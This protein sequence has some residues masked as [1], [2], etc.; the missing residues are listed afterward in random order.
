MATGPGD[1]DSD[2]DEDYSDM[3]PLVSA[4]GIPVDTPS[5]DEAPEAPAPVAGGGGATGATPPALCGWTAWLV[6]AATAIACGIMVAIG[7]TRAARWLGL[8]SRLSAAATAGA[9]GWALRGRWARAAPVSPSPSGPG[10][11][12]PAPSPPPSPGPSRPPEEDLEERRRQAWS[13]FSF[14]IVDVGELRRLMAL[15]YGAPTGCTVCEYSATIREEQR[16]RGRIFISID[17]RDSLLPGLHF[18]GDFR[19]VL[20]LFHWPDGVFCFTPCTH[21][22]R[23]DDYLPLKMQDGRA[24]HCLLLFVYAFCADGGCIFL[25]QP[26]TIVSDYLVP[27]SADFR[28]CDAG[29]PW[30]KRFQV[31]LRGTSRT[32]LEID[33]GWSV[34]GRRRGGSDFR[35]QFKDADA[36]DRFR[37]SWEDFPHTANLIV[38]QVRPGESTP[39]P[40]DYQWVVETVAVRWHAA[41]LPLFDR[42][43]ERSGIFAPEIEAYPIERG[44]GDGRRLE[45]V[46]P[47]SMRVDWPIDGPCVEAHK[48]DATVLP[49]HLLTLLDTGAE[50]DGGGMV[51]RWATLLLHARRVAPSHES[52][53]E[54]ALLRCAEVTTGPEGRPA[55]GDSEAATSPPAACSALAQVDLPQAAGELPLWCVQAAMSTTGVV[56]AVVA[57]AAQPLLLAHA[58][59]MQIFGAEL[60][61]DLPCAPTVRRWVSTLGC[62]GLATLPLGRYQGAATLIALPV[63]GRPKEEAV[64][65]S[66]AVRL[67]RVASGAAF[68]W[69]T[70]AALAGTPV[71]DVAAR[72]FAGIGGHA[73]GVEM[74]S[75]EVRTPGVS[76]SLG[77][78][79]LEDIAKTHRIDQGPAPLGYDALRENLLANQRLRDELLDDGSADAARW[80][81]RVIDIN[82]GDIPPDLLADL[83]NFDASGL[84]D[85]TFSEPYE[86]I[87]Q[88]WLPRRPQQDMSPT[89][90]CVRRVT[91]FICD[92][93]ARQQVERFFA[94]S[95]DDL[96][97]IHQHGANAERRRPSTVVVTQEQHCPWARGRYFDCTFSAS[98]CCVPLDFHAPFKS[99]LN[100]EMLRRELADY[101]DQR[102]LSNLV[103]GVR[104][105][106]DVELNAVLMPHLESLP[107]GFASVAKELGRM[108]A[109]PLQWYWLNATPPYWP[110][111]CNGKGAVSRKLE[112]DRYRPTTEAGAPRKEIYGTGGR[113]VLSLNQASRL[114]HLPLHYAADGRPEMR[115]WLAIKELPAPQE[116]ADLSLEEQLRSSK[117][118]KE[119]KPTIAHL[120]RD[121][122]RLRR[123]AHL[124]GEPIYLLTDDAKDYFP[125]FG[126]APEEYPKFTG[127]F[128]RSAVEKLSFVESSGNGELCFVSERVLGFGCHAASNIAQRASEA[129]LHIFRRRMDRLEAA[130]LCA[131]CDPRPVFQQWREGRLRLQRRRGV[132]GN[133]MR[134]YTSLMYT[135]DVV[136]VVV[137]VPRALRLIREWR[138]FLEE[139]GLMMA[140]PEKR[141]LGVWAP[142]LGINFYPML[143]LATVPTAKLL[144]AVDAVQDTLEGSITFDK[145]RSL[146]GLLEHI[147]SLFGYKKNIMF[148]LYE[149]HNLETGV[150]A[151]GPSAVV[152]PSDL[153]WKQLLAWASR[154]ATCGGISFLNVMDGAA[155]RARGLTG[156]VTSDAANDAAAAGLGGFCHGFYWRLSL[157]AS[158]AS[159]MHITL[160]EFL[161]C[162]FGF[163][164]F[165]RLLQRFPRVV[166]L[167]DAISTPYALSRESERSPLLR[168]AHRLL[169]Q[170]E[171]F[172]DLAPRASV[173]HLSG[174]AN[175]FSDAVSRALWPRLDALARQLGLRLTPMDL[176]DEASRIFD[177]CL[178][179]C[180]RLAQPEPLTLVAG[181]CVTVAQ[182]DGPE[183]GGGPREL[184]PESG[185]ATD[186]SLRL[187]CTGV[188]ANMMVHSDPALR[189][190][191]YARL[192][193]GDEMGVARGACAVRDALAGLTTGYVKAA[194]RALACYV[195]A[196]GS[197]ELVAEA[198]DAR[199]AMLLASAVRA[200]A[201][202]RDLPALSLEEAADA[203]RRARIR[204]SASTREL[205]GARAPKLQR[206]LSAEE[207]GTA[208]T[209]PCSRSNS[210]SEAYCEVCALRPPAPGQYACSTCAEL[211][212]SR[213]SGQLACFGAGQRP[214]SGY[215]VKDVSRGTEFGN[216]VGM[217]TYQRSEYVR[218][219]R[220]FEDICANLPSTAG[221]P[222]PVPL[223]E[224]LDCVMGPQLELTRR[225]L[226]NGLWSVSREVFEGAA[227]ALR[228][229]CAGLR[230]GFPCHSQSVRRELIRRAE[231]WA[232][233]PQGE[234]QRDRH[235]RGQPEGYPT[236]RE[237]ADDADGAVPGRKRR[238]GSRGGRK[239]TNRPRGDDTRDEASA[240]RLLLALPTAGGP[241]SSSRD[242]DEATVVGGS[243]S[244]ATVVEDDGAKIE[245]TS[246]PRGTPAPAV[247]PE[248]RLLS[249]R[250]PSLGIDEAFR[251]RA[252]RFASGL[253]EGGSASPASKSGRLVHLR[254]ADLSSEAAMQRRFR[255]FA[256]APVPGP[257]PDQRQRALSPVERGYHRSTASARANS[258]SE[259]YSPETRRARTRPLYE[260]RRRPSGADPPRD[261]PRAR[262]AIGAAP[263][264]GSEAAGTRP[265]GN[266]SGKRRAE[267]GPRYASC[268]TC[269]E[270]F[271]PRTLGPNRFS[272]C[273]VSCRPPSPPRDRTDPGEAS[274]S[275]ADGGA[276]G[277]HLADERAGMRGL[278]SGAAARPADATP[279]SLPPSPVDE[280]LL[281]RRRVAALPPPPSGAQ[282]LSRPRP[283]SPVERHTD[284]ACAGARSDSAS[285][286][287]SA[288][289]QWLAQ[290]NEVL[291]GGQ[292]RAPRQAP[293]AMTAAPI[294]AS[295]PPP[296][297]ATLDPR[298]T[299]G[300]T[301][302]SPGRDWSASVIEILSGQREPPLQTTRPVEV[303]AI[304]GATITTRRIVGVGSH[305]RFDMVEPLAGAKRRSE[306]ALRRA[307]QE[308]ARLASRRLLEDDSAGRIG[309]APSFLQ[310]ILLA[311]E[312]LMDYGINYN[313]NTKDAC[314]WDAWEE[315]CGVMNTTPLRQAS[316]VREYP[317]RESKLLGLFVLWIYPRLRPRSRADRW[318]K[319]KSA[320]AY[321]LA[322]IRI[323]Q[324][325]QVV[326]PSIKNVRAQ[327]R[328]LL[329]VAVNVF[330][331]GFL[332]PRRKEPFTMDMLRAVCAIPD[333]TRIGAH[334]WHAEAPVTILVTDLMCFLLRTGF[335]LA[336]VAAHSSGEIKYLTRA[337]LTA[338]VKRVPY[339]DPSPEIL[340]A[341]SVGDY[342]LVTPPRSKTDEWGEIHCPFPCTLIYSDDPL[343]PARR[344]R[345]AELRAPCRGEARSTTPLFARPGGVLLSHSY[346]DPILSSVLTYTIGRE[347]AAKYSWHSFRIGLACALRA[348]GCP[349]DV[350]QLICR[351]M[352][353]ESLRIYSLKGISEHAHWISCAENAPVDAVRGA[354]YPVVSAG[355]GAHDMAIECEAPFDDRAER[356]IE[357]ETMPT[358]WARPAAARRPS[359]RPSLPKRNP[360]LAR[361]LQD[362]GVEAPAR[363]TVPERQ[364]LLLVAHPR[365]A[366]QYDVPDDVLDAAGIVVIDPSQ[367][368]L[369]PPDAQRAGAA[370]PSTPTD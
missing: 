364:R 193:G 2:G 78:M 272:R 18:R 166:F 74:L 246:S 218:A 201:G 239:R 98:E 168:F 293:S 137:G 138:A 125:Q 219:V 76:F 278:Q 329:R 313:T 57:C 306:S 123:D 221:R 204:L 185:R 345:D 148:G 14:P 243:D 305:A 214:P 46:T 140:I 354:V 207:R 127:V 257:S 202:D 133:Q 337:N 308:M 215:E 282:G 121:A 237:D 288:R 206:P 33:P 10:A 56:L 335:R 87:K 224:R 340:L 309:C 112:K 143:G 268:W 332:A 108:A 72:A 117:F 232:D 124:L 15:P 261:E 259:V 113:R 267:G 355:E 248:G 82:P 136:H 9:A 270:P 94:E 289:L 287:P 269:H 298:P 19:L 79:S 295:R 338:V 307:S 251:R 109:P 362:H 100:L 35:R 169:R 180:R 81:E 20:H 348:A 262:G 217:R 315:F 190:M 5:D 23:R 279:P 230:R 197:V 97:N 213:F 320:L 93:A 77:R 34:D 44:R 129:L 41:N 238:R 8:W 22:L 106:A 158:A 181:G 211:E 363:A 321:P 130:Y 301:D 163:I 358:A 131:K 210:G 86:P 253:Y 191:A 220:G 80:A 368:A 203:M 71:A 16:R 189:V 200:A 280:P 292:S 194:V 103:E 73:H 342:F 164:V 101:P 11:S 314:A 161:A 327:V 128:L 296:A 114:R 276:G 30:T 27:Y 286:P 273:C 334:T 39:R 96:L 318:A 105:E 32:T 111:Y 323:F 284:L 12:S 104:I 36:R 188:L 225:H 59:G 170:T 88:A 341:M 184:G 236:T 205:E 283:L 330:G 356:D 367:V 64:C 208:P 70:L 47:L 300:A 264:P 55:R 245:P 92:P 328:G 53:V 132:K 31:Y 256:Q 135:D 175:A 360:A 326:L 250:A 102:L 89:P 139:V 275:N 347:N 17:V 48:V 153:M 336:E 183:L 67:K 303:S 325:W 234:R 126:F 322:I 281:P 75:S 63:A 260:T 249:L 235:P 222:L 43:W 159:V 54:T 95:R 333:G 144:R 369:A 25:E 165:R 1:E 149:P 258:G 3:P 199:S 157:N 152:A 116:I 226:N 151:F 311:E 118:P 91:D 274:S 241:P 171:A 147:R 233:W 331:P 212:A 134:L 37:S 209:Y 254:P 42:Y 252:G 291:Q 21:M 145:Y 223:L 85:L 51:S 13:T 68:L 299:H 119:V 228:C 349:P 69:C 172:G 195:R 187:P 155:P 24:L 58:H 365:L 60:A 186:A 160:L 174:D 28:A 4:A 196:G 247:P 120:K 227:F 38:S 154:L 346:M 66:R 255:R 312:D 150:A 26:D 263:A 339:V 45:G 83:P 84:D 317:A 350:V 229:R 290:V 90:F 110:C 359:T 240:P 343:N 177:R 277:R 173:A 353:A 122:T 65:R 50:G 271:E 351:W 142:W 310:D 99:H 266:R 176:P 302:R 324:R 7:M 242:D 352:C 231:A 198:G 146:V 6:T 49:L 265:P 192:L 61:L 344:L 316:F 29:D 297:T 179:L 294:V 357:N 319:P 366:H 361:L 370:A 285:E 62:A 115:A 167:S 244:E 182:P 304:P 141:T 216:P 178:E 156:V 107:L 162:A 40:L 52:A